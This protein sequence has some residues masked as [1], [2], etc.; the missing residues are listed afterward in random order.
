MATFSIEKDIFGQKIFF[1]RKGKKYY[2]GNVMY[3]KDQEQLEITTPFYE[4]K[5][6]K[7]PI[8]A[9]I[10]LEMDRNTSII[11]HQVNVE[12]NT[13]LY[14]NI[15]DFNELKIGK[16]HPKIQR[17]MTTK[18]KYN[19]VFTKCKSQNR[20]IYFFIRHL[21]EDEENE[22]GEIITGNKVDNILIGA[23]LYEPQH[24]DSEV[25]EPLKWIYNSKVLLN[26]LTPI[27]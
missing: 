22:F 13:L 5:A 11:Y 12:E 7:I 10:E 15:Q 18:K 8:F 27:S 23:Y 9:E 19:E 16:T 21:I 3:L 14:K 25:F 6:H 1:E 4:H 2:I 17:L 20:T 26:K 24:I